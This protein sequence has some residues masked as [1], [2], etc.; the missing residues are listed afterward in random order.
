MSNINYILGVNTPN[1]KKLEGLFSKTATSYDKDF[2]RRSAFNEAGIPV[3]RDPATIYPCYAAHY[4]GAI[5]ST[6]LALMPGY[7]ETAAKAAMAWLRKM[8][9]GAIT[10]HEIYG[11]SITV[12]LG[13]R[14]YRFCYPH[15]EISYKNENGDMVTAAV[16]A[17]PDIRDNDADWEGGIVPSY[18]HCCVMAQLWCNEQS[19]FIGRRA[20]YPETAYVVRITGN[21]PGDLT[22]RTVKYDMA[23]ADKL[24]VRLTA[25]YNRA[26]DA[27]KDPVQSPNVVS[28]QDWRE[29]L[30]EKEEFAFTSEDA[31]LYDLCAEYVS[32]RFQ[33]KELEAQVESIKEQMDSL[34]VQL[35]SMTDADADVGK[36]AAMDGC[37]YEVRHTKK[38]TTGA[39]VNVDLLQQFYPQYADMAISTRTYPK[40]RVEIGI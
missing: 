14:D 5:P 39:T 36:V 4:L 25:M 13:G 40:G 23:A 27:G 17:V 29:R 30:R 24:M 3:S 7:V 26:M 18:I 34:A 6:R 8:F 33:R 20:T 11:E 15:I 9:P 12:N 38:R 22:I 28:H 10:P 37:I 1:A 31:V 19:A 21:T 35:A 16:I 32:T 2:Y